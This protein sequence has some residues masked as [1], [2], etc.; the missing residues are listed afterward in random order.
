MT[1]N[2]KSTLNIQSPEIAKKYNEIII[3][4]D[5]YTFGFPTSIGIRKIPQIDYN[6]P[7]IRKGIIAGKNNSN[8]TIIID[9]PV[10]Q[11]NSGGPV[12]MVS[13]FGITGTEFTI[14]GIVSAWIPYEEVWVNTRTMQTNSELSN[15][16]YSVVVP[17]DKVLEMI[18]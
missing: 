4:N 12:V 5:I 15:S 8:S 7:L 9:C 11:G 6:I 3:G 17:I 10:Y 14:I 2:K 18:K 13:K 16:G 1:K